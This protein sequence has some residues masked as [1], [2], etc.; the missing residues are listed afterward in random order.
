[1]KKLTILLSFFAF[2]A[3]AQ[4]IKDYIAMYENYCNELVPDTVIQYGKVI[5]ECYPVYND[6]QVITSYFCV[7]KDT[8]WLPVECERFKTRGISIGYSSGVITSGQF[9]TGITLTRD[10]VTSGG[11]T[12]RV[13][14]ND[15]A[16][17]EITR[18]HVCMIKRQPVEP[19]GWDF[20]NFIKT[21]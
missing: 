19:F 10:G 18:Q 12:L 9:G 5:K 21:H 16:E 20:W 14:S 1:M 4:S 15:V 13:Y 2:T 17:E 8:T 6:K 11:K 7:N 3:N